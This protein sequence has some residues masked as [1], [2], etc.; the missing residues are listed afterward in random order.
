MAPPHLDSIRRIWAQIVRNAPDIDDLFERIIQSFY[1]KIVSTGDTT[2][3][4]GAHTGRHTIPLARLVGND[5]LV[6]AFEP[7]QAPATKLKQLLVTS[8]LDRRV[9]LRNEALANS[10][11]KHEFF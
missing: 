4:G 7:L 1:S 5:G 2:L 3:D 10:R 11:G 6:L 9:R 8:G